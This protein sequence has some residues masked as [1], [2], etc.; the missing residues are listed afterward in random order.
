MGRST[1]ITY[2]LPC[3]VI[4]ISGTVRRTLDKD[5]DPRKTIG[6]MRPEMVSKTVLVRHQADD[7]SGQ[8][9]TIKGGWFL[10]YKSSFSFQEDGRLTQASSETTGAGTE[11]ISAGATLAGTALAAARVTFG[12]DDERTAAKQRKDVYKREYE[13]VADERTALAGEQTRLRL[14]LRE[15]ETKLIDNPGDSAV[16][17]PQLQ[18]LRETQRL[19]DERIAVLDAHYA[20]WLAGRV[21]TVDDQFELVVKL[22]DLPATAEEAEKQFEGSALSDTSPGAAPAS[23]GELWTRYGLA[24][25]AR[26]ERPREASDRTVTPDPC[27]LVTRE[28]EPVTI[29]VVE[30]VSG[31]PVVTSRSRHLVAD[32]RS[33]LRVYRLERS[34]FGR[35]S[36]ALSFSENGYL[37]GVD[38]EGAASLGEAAKALA[39]APAALASGVDSFTKVQGGLTS[40]RQ[41]GLT[42]EVSRVKSQVELHQQEIL[43]AGVNVTAGDAARLERL[44][45]LKEILDAQA[46]IKD[47]DPALVTAAK[48]AAGADL[49]WYSGPEQK[50]AAE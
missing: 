35:R 3:A 42:A 18:A 44:K 22:A 11:L 29:S 34:W 30:H 32:A 12:P 33:P 37:S 31:Q 40:A 17:R 4:V 6:D 49:A 1:K 27:D 13:D 8:T 15:L 41:A 48:D 25:L 2:R 43:A 46:A 45:Q 24:V 20:A 50:P 7:G 10:Q 38:A 36:L 14:K 39:G 26:W 16:L 47:V 9:V 23:L 28:A 5:R 21:T 19:L